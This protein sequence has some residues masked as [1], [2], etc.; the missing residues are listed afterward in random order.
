MKITPLI[1]LTLSAAL[2][3]PSAAAAL[4]SATLAA[5]TAASSVVLM[6]SDT[7]T[8]TAADRASQVKQAKALLTE[9]N[10]TITRAK[11][12]QTAAPQADWSG[13]F[14]KLFRTLEE[15]KQSL[16]TIIK[17]G[18]P[19]LQP[20]VIF[21]RAELAIEIGTTISQS[22]THLQNKVQAAHVEIGFAITR[23]VLRLINIGATEQQ[24][25]EASAELVTVYNRVLTYPDLTPGDTATL[26]VKDALVKEIWKTRINRDKYILG[27]KSFQTY[28][29]LNK[30]ITK[31]VDVRL[32]PSAT[33][34]EVRD[35]ITVLKAAYAAAL[36]APD[37]IIPSKK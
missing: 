3:V 9:V 17:G 24:L 4:P 34:Q 2:S 21:A 25:K 16:D 32:N 8:S 26:Y 31:A 22:V 1:G 18:A 37:K 30:A 35:E 11:V 29:A 20:S 15:L 13:E 36:A 14:F 19:L 12:A 23:A 28:N 5:P 7:T 27:K 33:V 6:V 10:N